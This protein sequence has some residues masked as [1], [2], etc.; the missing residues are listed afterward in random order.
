ML[1]GVLEGYLLSCAIMTN[2]QC[3]LHFSLPLA[4]LAC[5]L[6]SNEGLAERSRWL[7]EEI[8]IN[9]NCPLNKIIA[10]IACIELSFARG[11]L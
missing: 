2:P 6:H 7:A 4:L 1:V 10:F 5:D 3:E 8:R 11:W 9:Q